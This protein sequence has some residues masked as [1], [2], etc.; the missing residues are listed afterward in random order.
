MVFSSSHV[1]WCGWKHSVGGAQD[2]WAKLQALSLHSLPPR[3]IL[4][5]CSHTMSSSFIYIHQ[6]S[7]EFM[8]YLR[9]TERSIFMNLLNIH[10]TSMMHYLE[11][12]E[13]ITLQM[14]TRVLILIKLF[15]CT[16]TSS[17]RINRYCCSFISL[18]IFFSFP[19]NIEQLF[20]LSKL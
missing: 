11:T 4:C 16:H 5:P 12:Y 9:S 2:E 17:Q 7:L 14:L 1:L 18:H 3:T 15:Q 8:V 6:D 13:K 20:T 19:E 10:W